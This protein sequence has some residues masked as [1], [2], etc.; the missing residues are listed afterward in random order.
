LPGLTTG[1]GGTHQGIED[2][3]LMRS[4]PNLVVI[5][6]CDATEIDQVVTAIAEYSGPVYMRL[7]RGQVPVVL[8]PTTYQFEIGRA[9]RLREG[10][11]VAIISMGLMTGRALERPLTWPRNESRQPSCT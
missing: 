1:Y 11:D 4:V 6:P 2:L 9:K 3:A 8:D 7:L 10:S 5:D